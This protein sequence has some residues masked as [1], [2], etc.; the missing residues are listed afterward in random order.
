MLA[1]VCHIVIIETE[2]QMA[3]M[4]YEQAIDRL[5]ALDVARW[6]EGER[7]ASR[8]LNRAN[9]PT[10]GLAINRL[11]H[12]DVDHIDT[13]LAAEAKRLLTDADRRVLRRG[14]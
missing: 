11:A 14:G 2:G 6:G 1:N 8:D 10:I 3:A 7:Q 13:A 5:V 12:Y 4:T 9:Y